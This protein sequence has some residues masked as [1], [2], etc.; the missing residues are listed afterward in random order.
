MAAKERKKGSECVRYKYTQCIR[1]LQRMGTAMILKYCQFVIVII[2]PDTLTCCVCVCVS[3]EI[4]HIPRKHEP[5]I[6][7]HTRTQN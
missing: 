5:E 7:T 3:F 2:A 4:F 6:K 1:Y